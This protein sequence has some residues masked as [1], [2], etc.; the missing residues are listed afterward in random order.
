MW[1]Y[2]PYPSKIFYLHKVYLYLFQFQ[3]ISY[4]LY[5]A[6]IRRYIVLLRH[7]G[8]KRNRKKNLVWDNTA[9]T[10]YIK[11]KRCE[12]C[13]DFWWLRPTNWLWSYI[14]YGNK[15]VD[16]QTPITIKINADI[17]INVI[18]QVDLFEKQSITT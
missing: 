18:I 7:I 8:D 2:K 1:N 15:Y 12:S 5:N 16:L 9:C 13:Y 17:L 14:H 10:I 6:S 4:Y 11:N 3:F